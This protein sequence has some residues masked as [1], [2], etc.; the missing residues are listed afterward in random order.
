MS[1]KTAEGYRVACPRCAGTGRVERHANVKGGVCF[2]CNGS[3]YRVRKSPP[4]AP[5]QR[6][7]VSACS[8]RTGERVSPVFWLLAKTER[9][10]LTRARAQ[11]AKGNGYDPATVEVS[12]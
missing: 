3:G 5:A 8:R 12:A 6:F 9:A 7:A 1:Q 10:A 2:A 11:I 4:S